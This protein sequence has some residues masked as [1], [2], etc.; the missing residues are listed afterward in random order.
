MTKM[1]ISQENEGIRKGKAEEVSKV[2]A[3]VDTDG[4]GVGRTHGAARHHLLL[5]HSKP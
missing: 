3:K 2:G 5:R 4:Y 1:G